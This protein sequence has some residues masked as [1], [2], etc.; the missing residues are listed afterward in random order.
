MDAQPP[1]GHLDYLVERRLLRDR[2]IGLLCRGEGEQEFVVAE[3]N[4]SKIRNKV[5]ADIFFLK[6][7]VPAR[8]GEK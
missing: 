7:A 4:L 5:H 8:C 2:H 1:P 6:S 3:L